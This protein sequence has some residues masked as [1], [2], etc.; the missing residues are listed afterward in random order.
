MSF[1]KIRQTVSIG[2]LGLLMSLWL[3]SC[4][5]VDSFESV[6][7]SNQGTPL[8]PFDVSQGR[9]FPE[10]IEKFFPNAKSFY[11]DFP[12]FQAAQVGLQLVEVKRLTEGEHSYN[13]ANLSWSAD[14]VYLGYE[15]VKHDTREILVKDLVGNYSRQLSLMPRKDESALIGLLNS[16]LV[17]FN[18]GLRW[19]QDST[20]FA[21]MSNGG[22]GEFNI[23]V[24]AVG[25]DEEVIAKS[26]T[27]DGFATWNPKFQE[28]AFVSSRS[29]QGDIYSVNLKR[30]ELRRLSKNRQVDLFP[31]WFPDGNGLIYSSGD[32][33]NHNLV[34][35]RRDQNTKDWDTPHQLTNWS[36]D[37]LKPSISPNGQLV[38]FYSSS[39]VPGVSGKIEWNL[40]VIRYAPGKSYLAEDLRKTVVAKN[41]VVDINTG[42][43]WTPDGS[44][45]IYIAQDP[46]RFNPIYCYDLATGVRYLLKTGTKMNRDVMI[47]KLG[48]ISFRAQD[49]VWDRVFLALTN[50]G[51]QIQNQIKQIDTVSYL[52]L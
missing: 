49:G 6:F 3:V 33:L 5:V 27:K 10:F 2:Y 37:D 32:S 38:S 40:H 46:D 47:S 29:G 24:G 9:Y 50:Q 16:H 45:I 20:Q 19:S 17:S 42:P 12:N 51:S 44:K 22:E 11:I 41:V 48:I 4:A 21:F 52:D 15:I 25:R 18:A 28:L 36:Q 31:E 30:N 14:G 35:L 23:Y 39:P 13:E 34:V 1:K 8:T 26:P 7:Y 43:A